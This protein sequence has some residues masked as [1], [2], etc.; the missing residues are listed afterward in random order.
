MAL[1][2][3]IGGEVSSCNEAPITTHESA[4]MIPGNRYLLTRMRLMLPGGSLAVAR[5]R[6]RERAA[7]R[8]GRDDVPARPPRMVDGPV[9]A[10]GG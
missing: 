7:D 4:A 3:I 5:A 6:P 1:P 9:R 8:D 10:P 2:T